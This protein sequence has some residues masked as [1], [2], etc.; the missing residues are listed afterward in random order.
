MR[1]RIRECRIARHRVGR[2]GAWRHRSR[3]PRRRSEKH[4]RVTRA[5]RHTGSRA[6]RRLLGSLRTIALW[7]L[8][9]LAGPAGADAQESGLVPNPGSAARWPADTASGDAI[10]RDSLSSPTLARGRGAEIAQA[11]REY[12]E[13]GSART[14]YEGDVVTFPYGHA[15]PILT[16]A[17]LRACIVELEPGEILL[18]KIAGDTERWEIVPAPAGPDGRTTL[19]VVKP[20]DCDLT[21]NL[22][23][24]TDRRIY[25]LTL[26]VPPCKPAGAKGAASTSAT[27]PQQRYVRHVRFYYPDELVVAWAKPAPVR[28]AP[29]VA[30]LNFG[31]R[32]KKD[33]QFPW[34]P[35]QVFDDGARVYI[36]LPGDARHS[37][38]PAL[39]VLEADGGKTLLNYTLLSGDTYV[40]DRLFDRAALVAGIDGKERRVVLERLPRSVDGGFK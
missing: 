23:L 36:K 6:L 1:D 28:M 39:F 24:A 20:H 16:C 9:A 11:T 3:R 2:A 34:A 38:A 40:T 25:D 7:V 13:T 8:I 5:K 30:A 21:S 27:N 32:V 4:P 17:V 26:D 19:V 14:I 37:D 12:R 35:A 10:G 18:S 15:Q 31:Y 29:D 22:V 33:K